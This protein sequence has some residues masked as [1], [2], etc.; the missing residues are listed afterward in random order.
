MS[1]EHDYDNLGS[2]PLTPPP[3]YYQ[4]LALNI[5]PEHLEGSQF[6]FAGDEKKKRSLSDI[7]FFG[8]GSS[9]MSGLCAGGLWGLVEHKRTFDE[10]SKVL[11]RNHCL[12]SMTK[13]G[14][15]VGNSVAVIALFYTAITGGIGKLRDR[16][17]VLNDVGGGG[18]TGA[19][20]K[21]TSGVRQGALGLAIGSV[22]GFALNAVNGTVQQGSSYTVDTIRDT[23]QDLFDRT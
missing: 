19:L 11:R 9:Y 3:R 20:Y 14:I 17:D 2:V 7:M 6:V 4:H 15:F 5:Q 18:L 12:N 13:R 1:R 21:C 23:Y 16:D 22:C 10:S 8:I